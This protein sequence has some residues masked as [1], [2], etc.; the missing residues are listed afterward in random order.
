[1]ARVWTFGYQADFKSLFKK[2]EAG[3]TE[4]ALDLL[5]DLRNKLLQEERL[6]PLLEKRKKRVPLV[7]VAHS[8]GGLVIKEVGS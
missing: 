8:M 5:D 7:F 6:A 4:F 1:M 2:S 3:I